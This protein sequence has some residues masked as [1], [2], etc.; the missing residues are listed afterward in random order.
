MID[1]LRA[2]AD[3]LIAAT[4]YMFTAPLV[5]AAI[6]QFRAKASTVP[7]ST[8][9]LTVLG[10]VVNGSV[11]AALGMWIAVSASIACA[12]MWLVIALQRRAY[13]AR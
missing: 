8:S 1:F 7:L 9:V 13:G 10:L 4:G 6:E 2:N 12:S 5:L 3:F 11:F